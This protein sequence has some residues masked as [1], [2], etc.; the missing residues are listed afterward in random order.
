[1]TLGLIAI[2]YIALGIVFAFLA[3]RRKEPALDV[4]F[5]LLAWPIY[6]SM[7]SPKE[8]PEDVA[9]REAEA[10]REALVQVADAARGSTFATLFD[11]RAEDRVRLELERTTERVRAIDLELARS[12][13]TIAPSRASTRL[14]AIRDRDLHAMR[15][16]VQLLAALRGEILIARHEGSSAEGTSALV[17]EVWARVV[18]LGEAQSRDGSF[19]LEASIEE[20]ASPPI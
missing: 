5:V 9:F 8:A 7:L 18:G 3:W 11:Q 19:A 4:L 2:A 1:M 17:S 10:V 16:L 15:E 12:T 20:S 13:K 14:R 6:A